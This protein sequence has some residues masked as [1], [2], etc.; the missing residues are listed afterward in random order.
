MHRISYFTWSVQWKYFHIITA[1]SLEKVL[2]IDELSTAEYT[3]NAVAKK[4]SQDGK[5]IKYYVAY[6]GK[7]TA[8]VDFEKIDGKWYFSKWDN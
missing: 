3:Y 4:H 2:E 1:S 7:V 8:G 6:E 5:E